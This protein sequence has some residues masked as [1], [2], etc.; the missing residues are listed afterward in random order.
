MGRMRPPTEAQS[1]RN[2]GGE[3]IRFLRLHQVLNSAL[4]KF[5]S[6]VDQRLDNEIAWHLIKSPILG[7]I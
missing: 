6:D 1:L 7:V 5:D 2:N 4:V 3:L